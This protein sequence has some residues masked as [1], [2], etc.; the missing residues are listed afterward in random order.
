MNQA[1]EERPVHDILPRDSVIITR[2]LRDESDSGHP[3]PVRPRDCCFTYIQFEKLFPLD[4]TA[5]VTLGDGRSLKREFTDAKKIR[6]ALVEPDGGLDGKDTDE[7]L[8]GG[9]GP[10]V[11]V[12]ID[13]ADTTKAKTFFHFH[14]VLCCDD[15]KIAAGE[16]VLT[17]IIP[18][19]PQPPLTQGQRLRLL[20]IK[21]VRVDPCP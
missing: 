17:G 11:D 2:P 15:R 4:V 8:V 6:P 19:P 5:R 9:L 3:T 13:V 14:F 21:L 1:P 20:G 16:T 10:C 12:D 7:I 18:P